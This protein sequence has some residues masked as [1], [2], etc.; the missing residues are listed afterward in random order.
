MGDGGGERKDARQGPGPG[1]D[2]ILHY[3]DDYNDFGDACEAAMLNDPA[4]NTC[5]VPPSLQDLYW[6]A[7]AFN[8]P[9]ETRALGPGFPGRPGAILGRTVL[10]RPRGPGQEFFCSVFWPALKHTRQ[11]KRSPVK[12]GGLGAV[13][14]PS[15]APHG[16]S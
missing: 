7:K 15:W 2:G 1:P 3:G 5:I 16:A 8:Y 14:G 9:R 4:Y 13:L 6:P 11:K 12:E 10:G